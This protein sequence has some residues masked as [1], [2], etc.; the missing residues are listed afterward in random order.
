VA[1]WAP[2]KIARVAELSPGARI[3]LVFDGACGPLALDW[4][5][6]VAPEEE[7][8]L[9]FR[10]DDGTREHEIRIGDRLNIFGSGPVEDARRTS[11]HHVEFDWVAAGEY[12]ATI[13]IVFRRDE[14]NRFYS[15]QVSILP[16][17]AN[18]IVFTKADLVKDR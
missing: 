2:C 7:H 9:Y 10:L 11:D 15:K 4:P 13:Q 6:L 3:S 14:P 8:L 12:R 5:A 17:V 1:I 16:G 18:E